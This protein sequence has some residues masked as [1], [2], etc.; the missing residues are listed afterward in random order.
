MNERWMEQ[1]EFRLRVITSDPAKDVRRGNYWGDREK[2]SVLMQR[3]SFPTE[4]V[5]SNKITKNRIVLSFKDSPQKPLRRRPSDWQVAAATRRLYNNHL[6]R[7]PERVRR[8]RKQAKSFM[9]A[10][11]SYPCRPTQ[12]KLSQ[13]S[14]FPILKLRDTFLGSNVVSVRSYNY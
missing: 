11:H 5:L 6:D 9:D 1:R 2:A 8:A 3:L 14:G 4:T 10:S 7:D 13:I 12:A